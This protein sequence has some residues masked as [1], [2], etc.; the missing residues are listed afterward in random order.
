VFVAFLSSKG[1]AH[2]GRIKPE[3]SAFGEDGSSGAAALVSGVALLI[4]QAYKQINNELPTA[5]FTKAV[6]INSADDIGIPGPDFGSGFGNMNAY[7]SINTIVNQHYFIGSVSNNIAQSFSLE[8]PANIRRIKITLCWNDPPA[9]VNSAK[10][11]VNDIDLELINN[12]NSWKPWVLNS[13]PHRDSLLLPATRKRDS[14]NNVEQITVQNPAPGTYTIRVYGFS[15]PNGS[16]PFSIA[17]EM[18][19]ADIFTWYYPTA[20]DKIPALEK[21]ILRWKTSFSNNSGKLETSFDNGNSWQLIS[22]TVDLSKGYYNWHSPAIASPV[23]FRMTINGNTFYSDTSIISTPPALKVGFNCSDSLL[24]YWNK[25]PSVS[26]YRVYYL[27][28]KYLQ[29]FTDV[30][31]SLLVIPKSNSASFYYAVAPVINLDRIGLSSYTINYTTQGVD[32]YIK[33]FLAELENELQVRINIE[34]GTVYQLTNMEVEKL[35]AG[36]FISIQTISSA[37]NTQFTA[38]DSKL[39]R[40][41]NTYRLKLNLTNGKVIYSNPETVYYFADAEYLIFPNPV[42]ISSPRIQVLSK[43]LIKGELTMYNSIG[44]L[45]IVQRLSSPNETV[46]VE[47]LQKGVYILHIQQEGKKDFTSKI[48]LQ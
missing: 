22:D 4:Q 29:T 39:N 9:L 40:G 7:K 33:N 11:L 20:L 3:L 24:L 43:D 1:P 2:D 18:D 32:C 26:R 23:V 30:N 27:G 46:S 35:T 44:Q 16:Q 10:S 5:A 15:I 21:N 8:I 25:I 47:R 38:I 13:Q 34:L 12:L 48:I 17:Y 28:E 31:D 45:V 42:S 37:G 41:G 6:L 19:T 36:S 14:L